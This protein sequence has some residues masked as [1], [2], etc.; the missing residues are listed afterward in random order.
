MLLALFCL[1]AGYKQHTWKSPALTALV[2]ILASVV[3]QMGKLDQY[4]RAFG[5][6]V[7]DSA[8]LE[9]AAEAAVKAPVLCFALWGVGKGFAALKRWITRRPASPHHTP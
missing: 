8:W 9:I 4:S 1:Y 5:F 7:P 3:L 2:A 6:A